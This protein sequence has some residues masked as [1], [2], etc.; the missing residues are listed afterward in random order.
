MS[1]PAH[2]APV[3]IVAD[4]GGTNTRIA[5]FDGTNNG[6]RALT[7]YVNR[8]F[9]SLEEIFQQWLE[10]LEEPSPETCCLAVAAPPSEDLVVMS[11]MD[12]SFSCSELA[13]ALGFAQLRRLNDF[14][15]NAYALPHLGTGERAILSK[16]RSET[17]AGRLA[18][19]GPGTGLG[20]ACLDYFDGV[21]HSF[22]CEPGHMGLAPGNDLELELFRRLLS[23]Y[24]NIY[25][26]LLVSG[27]GLVRLYHTLGDIRGEATEGLEPAD[28][29]ERALAGQDTL[30]VLALETFGALLG[31][32]CGDFL[33]ANG[34]YRGLY[35]AGGIVPGMI[36]F[37][38]ASTFQ[39]RLVEKGAM[40]RILADVPVYV[41]TTGQPGLIGAAHAPL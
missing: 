24:G 17:A 14:E 28:I 15:A 38:A 5:L 32:I 31:S 25:A 41:I 22:A 34:A 20:G 35:L 26:E 1:D 29:C 40:S 30:C 21:P 8:D 36:D 6:F 39:Q 3:R 7:C 12:W 19:V 37:L 4:V 11:N 13:I 9:N 33:L 23:Q 18:T 16:G 2:S 27:P 10:A